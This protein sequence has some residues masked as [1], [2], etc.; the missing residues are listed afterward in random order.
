MTGIELTPAALRHTMLQSCT[1]SLLLC[2]L[3][4][5]AMAEER[6]LE[7]LVAVGRTLVH[8]RDP[9]DA[10]DHFERWD[11]DVAEWLDRKYPGTGLSAHW[12][13][14]PAS[15]LVSGN[16]YYDDSASWAL[17][18]S[19]VQRRLAWLSEFGTTISKAKRRSSATNVKSD[20]QQPRSSK[21]FVVH[22]YNEA[23]RE[24]VARFLEKLGLQPVILHEQPNKGRTIIEKFVDYSDVGFAVV[25][26]TAD[27]AGGLAGSEPSKLKPRARQN[28]VFELGYFLAKLGRE[29]VCALH[30]AGIELPSDYHGVLYIPIDQGDSWRL[31]LA[32]EL[33]A[34]GF[35]VDLNLAM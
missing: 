18:K 30:Q 33:K 8:A 12:S 26:L 32:R 19:A 9:C 31:Q 27:D 24:T 23:I 15:M 10:H 5:T 35:P 6:T 16:H 25:L 7:N 22:G 17:F 3:D 28:V 1:K 34:V 14:Q 2:G 20:L 4:E 29:R 13:A 11:K 21:I